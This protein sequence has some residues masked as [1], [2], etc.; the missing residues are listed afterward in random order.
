MKSKTNCIALFRFHLLRDVLELLARF[1][2]RRLTEADF[3]ALD[4]L[5]KTEAG[6]LIDMAVVE[7]VK[8]LLERKAKCK[9]AQSGF[10]MASR[11]K[12]TIP[13]DGSE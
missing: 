5:I 9:R 12:I 8:R 4:E 3:M 10:V 1:R 7:E 6:Q 11:R 13:M 2:R